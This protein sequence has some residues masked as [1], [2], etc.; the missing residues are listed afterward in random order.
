MIMRILL[1]IAIIVVGYLMC[2]RTNWFYD[3]LG[4]VDWAERAFVSG[5]S[6]FFY[7]LL[8]VAVIIV[9]IIVLTD[10]YDIIVGGFVAKVF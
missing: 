1:G 4:P 3:I 6:R 7:K 9:G 5:G 2:L 8:G 10:L